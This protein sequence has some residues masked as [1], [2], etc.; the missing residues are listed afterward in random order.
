[1]TLTPARF[2]KSLGLQ[3]IMVRPYHAEERS[4]EGV[5][6]RKPLGQPPPKGSTKEAW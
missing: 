3:A 2:S 5:D 4:E 1:M 6:M